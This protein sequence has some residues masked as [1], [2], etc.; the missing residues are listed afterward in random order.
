MN[1]YQ[2]RRQKLFNKLEDNSVAIL[3]SGYSV[4]NS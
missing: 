4:Q 2:L 3:H 1:C